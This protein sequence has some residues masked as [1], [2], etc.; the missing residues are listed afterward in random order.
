MFT[1]FK[2]VALLSK[3][4]DK[5]IDNDMRFYEKHCDAVR[6]AERPAFLSRRSVAGYYLCRIGLT[7][8]ELLLHF[9]C[10]QGITAV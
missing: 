6:G 7:R 9:F 3:T 5:R 1:W 8:F 2:V 10:R 4:S